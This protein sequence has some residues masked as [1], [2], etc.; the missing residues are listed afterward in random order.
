MSRHV[1]LTPHQTALKELAC[2]QLAAA[3]ETMRRLRDIPADRADSEALADACELLA[4]ADDCLR[5][6]F[7]DC[8][9]EFRAELDAG[10]TD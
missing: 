2:R 5:N 3:A 10:D 7:G 9:E 6:W 8:P 1:P 4:R